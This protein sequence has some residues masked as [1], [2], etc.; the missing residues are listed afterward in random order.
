MQWTIRRGGER[1]LGISVLRARHDDDDDVY[2][3]TADFHLSMLNWRYFIIHDP[4]THYDT[5]TGKY[6]Y[7]L[8]NRQI[9]YNKEKINTLNTEA[10]NVHNEL[11][12]LTQL[13]DKFI[14]QFQPETKRLT[15]TLERILKIYIDKMCLYQLSKHAYIYIVIHI[16]ICFVLSALFCVARQARFRKLGSKRR[17]LK[18]QFQDSTTQPRGN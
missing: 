4:A 7:S 12:N 6:R 11:K 1:G 16:H 10:H 5:E 9:N 13:N 18:R 17:W 14:H 15:R 2:S 3:W 8:V